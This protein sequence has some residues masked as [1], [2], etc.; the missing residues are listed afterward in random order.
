LQFEQ[1]GVDAFADRT[2]QR[3]RESVILEIEERPDRAEL[4]RGILGEEIAQQRTVMD[5]TDRVAF[6]HAVFLEGEGFG[7]FDYNAQFFRGRRGKRN[8]VFMEK[9]I[10]TRRRTA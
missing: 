10:Q 5:Q 6:A 4:G 8:N 9:F 7:R 2:A 3:E 1:S